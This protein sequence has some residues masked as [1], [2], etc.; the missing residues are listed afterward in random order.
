M[1]KKT[2]RTLTGIA[3]LLASVANAVEIDGAPTGPEACLE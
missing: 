2:I 1:L 3:F